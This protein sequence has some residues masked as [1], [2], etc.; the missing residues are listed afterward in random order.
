MMGG[1]ED[2]DRIC[3]PGHWSDDSRLVAEVCPEEID[4]TNGAAYRDEG[5]YV[6]RAEGLQGEAA[7]QKV[8]VFT[9][10]P[11]L[12]DEEDADADGRR[13]DDHPLPADVVCELVEPLVSVRQDT[14]E[15]KRHV[16]GVIP[17]PQ[18]KG[19]VFAL[20]GL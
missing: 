18:G 5:A 9:R 3:V 17:E 15:E 16:F 7:S 20:P 13:R 12:N 11:G 10:A 14:H 2:E 4:E 19:Q 6:C 8:K 1:V